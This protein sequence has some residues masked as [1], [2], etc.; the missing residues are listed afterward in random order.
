MTGPVDDDAWVAGLRDRVGEV[1]PDVPVD[2]AG[3]VR[4]GRR[5]HAARTLAV[6][7][8]MLTAACALAVA[9]VPRA[10][11]ALGESS[12]DSAGSV[13]VGAPAADSAS[14][15]ARP[16]RALAPAE[17]AAELADGSLASDPVLVIQPD[18]P[19]PA[20]LLAAIGRVEPSD[21]FTPSPVA[22]SPA[23]WPAATAGCLDEAGW[24]VTLTS[25]AWEVEVPGGQA[26]AF[27][28]DLAGCVARYPLR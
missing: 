1:A 26:R 6:R 14:A 20:A 9:V 19:D 7:G 8:V 28:V 10:L 18:V 27:L 21:R 17:L 23:Q 5:R 2:V 13:A 15:G 4:R 22:V 24:A 25:G 16:A 12:A 11:G 3:A